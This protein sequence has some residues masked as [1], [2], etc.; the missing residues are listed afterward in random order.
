MNP[1]E[2]TDA[3]ATPAEG[4]DEILCAC[5]DFRQSDLRQALATNPNLSFDELLRQTRAG[6]TCTA[7]LLDLEYYFT[8]TPRDRRSTGT[9]TG[10]QGKPRASISL[11]QRLYRVIDRLSPLSPM[12]LAEFMPVL[13]GKGIEQFV[14][15]ANNSLL[16][17]HDTCAPDIEF[18]VIVRD[19]TGRKVHHQTQVIPADGAGR[20]LVSSHLGGAKSDGLRAGSVRVSRRAQRPGIRGTTRPQVEIVSKAGSCAV[21]TQA[22]G[23][24]RDRWISAY[25]RPADERLFA[26]AV[27]ASSKPLTVEIAYPFAQDAKTGI[28]PAVHSLTV[29]PYGTV[30]HEIKLS[31]AASA[32]LTGG[33]FGIRLNTGGLGKLHLFC[34]TPNLDRFSIDHL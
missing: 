26:T 10:G 13:F 19:E 18:D 32:A 28:E 16:Y 21:H 20:I 6:G 33:L 5:A 8:V 7:C 25:H 9:K 4:H 24:L 3:G 1:H 12:P 30:L 17:E 34:A 2:K 23:R 31:D 22:P 15:I 11:K 29:P 27:N 14:C